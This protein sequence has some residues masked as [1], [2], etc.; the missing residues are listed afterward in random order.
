MPLNSFASAAN[1]PV[2]IASEQAFEAGEGSGVA[3]FRIAGEDAAPYC[4]LHVMRE[5]ENLALRLPSLDD[6]AAEL[7]AGA[8]LHLLEHHPVARRAGHGDDARDAKCDQQQRL[9]GETH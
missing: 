6:I 9:A 7:I 1:G 3:I 4:L 2:G 8:L 5:P